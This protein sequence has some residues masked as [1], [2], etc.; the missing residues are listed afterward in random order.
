MLSHN[1]KYNTQKQNTIKYDRVWIIFSGFVQV[2]IDFLNGSYQGAVLWICAEKSDAFQSSTIF[3]A[4]IYK[5][6]SQHP[7]VIDIFS[8]FPS[9]HIFPN[10]NMV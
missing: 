9:P 6:I 10:F 8:F 3:L 7:M 1:I 4:F 5:V 2:R